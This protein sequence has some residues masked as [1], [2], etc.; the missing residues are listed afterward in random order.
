MTL[1]EYQA[2]AKA[3]S[4]GLKKAEVRKHE[5]V[6]GKLLEKKETA[7]DKIETITSQLKDSNLYNAGVAK[8]EHAD[9]L[10]F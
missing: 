6:K 1:E 9:L 5:E 8:S 2:Q 7:N 4:A 10:G 3:K